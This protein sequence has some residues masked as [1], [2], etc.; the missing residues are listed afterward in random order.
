MVVVLIQLGNDSLL[1]LFVFIST[2]VYLRDESVEV[3][4]R[5]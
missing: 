2:W 5:T 1:V 3:G 4:V